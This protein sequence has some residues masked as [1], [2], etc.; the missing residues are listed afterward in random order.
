MLEGLAAGSKGV[1]DGGSQAMNYAQDVSAAQTNK[2][3]QGIYDEAAAYYQRLRWF[4]TRLT[5]LEY[6]QTE[7]ALLTQFHFVP[8]N[9]GRYLEIGC[10][11]GTWTKVVAAHAAEVTALDIS[12]N[13][14][15]QAR[16]YVAGAANITFI[17]GDAAQYQPDSLL[18]GFFSFRVIEY[19]NGWQDMLARVAT[20]VRPGGRAVICTKTPFSVYRGTGRERWFTTGVRRTLERLVRRVRGQPEPPADGFWQKYI[21]PEAL[22]HILEQAGFTDVQVVPAIYGLPIFWRG[23]CQYPL[24]PAFAEPLLMRAF[25]RGRGLANRLPPGLRRMSLVFSESYVLSA[26][27]R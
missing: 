13:M 8:E 17:H 19:V 4:K 7:D 9:K 6:D 16:R 20:H 23:T 15:E 1:L 3:V 22:G 27:K 2:G 21:S 25:E 10:G 11:P 24:A 14:I 12:A 26:T 18:D 5:R